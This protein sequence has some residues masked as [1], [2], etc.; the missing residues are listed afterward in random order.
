MHRNTW[1]PIFA[2]L[3]GSDG[4]SNAQVLETVFPVNL[5]GVDHPPFH[6]VDVGHQR[7]APLRQFDGIGQCHAG[8]VDTIPELVGDKYA[9]T[10]LELLDKG[11]RTILNPGFSRLIG[12]G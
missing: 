4:E 6:N 5:Q 10:R 11:G 1:Q 9:V 3:E 8:E 2:F 12:L 7:I